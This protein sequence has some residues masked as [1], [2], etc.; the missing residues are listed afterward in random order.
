MID[1]HDQLKDQSSTRSIS[2][3]WSVEIVHVDTHEEF[4]LKLNESIYFVMLHFYYP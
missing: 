1:S 3:F 4:R 2:K